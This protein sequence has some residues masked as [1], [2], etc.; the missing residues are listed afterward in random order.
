MSEVNDPVDSS[1]LT[2]DISQESL[3]EG[4]K[5]L[6]ERHM[7]GKA[8]RTP[9]TAF[10]DGALPSTTGKTS[11][12]MSTQWTGTVSTP[13]L[14]IS[15]SSST[16]RRQYVDIKEKIEE[17]KKLKAENFELKTKLFIV[18]RELPVIKDQ[19]GKDFTEDYLKCR[20]QL[21]NE[22]TRRMEAE[23]QLRTA[24]LEIMELNRKH[25]EEV[26]ELAAR[27]MRLR[28]ERDRLNDVYSMQQR[29]LNA[30][31]QQVSKLTAQVES[32]SRQIVTEDGDESLADTSMSNVSV[33][34]SRDRIIEELKGA[35]LEMTVKEKQRTHMLEKMDSLNADLTRLNSELDAQQK[36]LH[37]ERELRMRT[38][39]CVTQ[40]QDQ[41]G[42]AERNADAL[43]QDIGCVAP[44]NITDDNPVVRNLLGRIAEISTTNSSLR[45][46][47][48]R[49]KKA[50]AFDEAFELNEDLDRS[51]DDESSVWD[52][53]RLRT[54]NKKAAAVLA[55]EGL[56]GVDLSCQEMLKMKMHE[57]DMAGGS[58]A[59]RMSTLERESSLG[60]S[61][62]APQ[63]LPE[64]STMAGLY[65][66]SITALGDL[67]TLRRSVS[68]L[69]RISIRLF[70][71]LRGSAAFLQSLL[72]EL[73]QS[74]KGRDF[75]K[76][77][78][79]MR[80]EFGRS[81]T[82]AA[83][84]LS[85]VDG[86]S[87]IFLLMVFV[88]VQS[89]GLQRAQL[90]RS[91]NYSMIS[92]S[93][94]RVDFST[95]ASKQS[96]KFATDEAQTS[97]HFEAEV[98][99]MKATLADMEYKHSAL[100]LEF[101]AAT[102][103]KTE[104]EKK[105]DELEKASVEKSN[106]ELALSKEIETLTKRIEELNAQNAESEFEL[107]RIAGEAQA[108]CQDLEMTTNKLEQR[109]EN[110]QQ[111]LKDKTA[112]MEMVNDSLRVREEEFNRYKRVR[113]FE[114]VGLLFF[115]FVN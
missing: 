20:D 26:E 100:K 30:K 2:Q 41:L 69:R 46:E 62:L 18:M 107:R 70:E 34:S 36:V 84:I 75:I 8:V 17:N 68:L 56:A 47:V 95:V 96:P 76:E 12:V 101:E 27:N 49:L 31:V 22:Q 6:L 44:E 35:L 81:A 73:G 50:G 10:S 7:H 115:P 13:M 11:S 37:E 43:K 109:L 64:M 97:A 53:S 103:C 83:D 54:E 67:D 39:Q 79:A 94:S 4:V 59:L 23:E 86:S 29:E 111:A 52:P 105:I 93:A 80:I 98:S 108:R 32:I 15:A 82:T 112:E 48:Q 113:L 16:I 5:E 65:S 42:E 45:D 77:I 40:L 60:S 114:I 25:E 55:R 92:I 3:D 24:E 99:V 102:R 78:E 63:D 90:E 88:D 51:T 57:F 66:Q 89:L 58:S 71:K 61:C 91:M 9:I 38:A 19:E 106:R 74:E 87:Q 21:F 28:E 110:S 85:G 33:M 1:I 104:L 72:D 14:P